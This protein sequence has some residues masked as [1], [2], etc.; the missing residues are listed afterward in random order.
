MDRTRTTIT[1]QTKNV[2]NIRK[3]EHTIGPPY[4][5]MMSI[6]NVKGVRRFGGDVIKKILMMKLLSNGSP[7]GCHQG[8]GI[9]EGKSEGVISNEKGRDNCRRYPETDYS[10]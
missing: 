7:G 8:R 2:R 9:V 6:T 5:V 10:W 4:Q 3:Q 1:C